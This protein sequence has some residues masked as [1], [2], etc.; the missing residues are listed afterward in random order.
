M[1]LLSQL[2]LP[3]AVLADVNFMALSPNQIAQL[4]Y[5]AGFR[6]SSLRMAVAIALAESGGNPN[7]YNPEVAAGTRPGH[8]S[9]GLWQIYGSAHP[10]Y[11]NQQTFNPI[12]NAQ[13][14]FRVY[15]QAGNKFTPWST[16]KN[17]SAYKISQNLNLDMPSGEI[18]LTGGTGP[19]ALAGVAS[20]TL[21]P[22][23]PAGR[24]GSAAS[25][26]ATD[27]RGP[28]VS[29]SLLPENIRQGLENID[30]QFVKKSMALGIFGFMLLS[31]GAIMLI[32]QMVTPAAKALVKDVAGVALAAAL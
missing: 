28:L 5:Q 24:T 4:A 27:E 7:A 13:A 26:I 11:D 15:S 8:G 9:R 22:I 3:A 29:V 10:E 19:A 6:G 21:N 14:A 18:N 25:S 1:V 32:A 23:S 2:A 17:G 30:P 16:F 12:T 20:A 31:I